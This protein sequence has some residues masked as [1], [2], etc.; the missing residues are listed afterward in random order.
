LSL[1]KYRS[2]FHNDGPLLIAEAE[3]PP[4]PTHLQTYLNAGRRASN[5]VG[6]DMSSSS[7]GRV[8][9]ASSL[10]RPFLSSARWDISSSNAKVESQEDQINTTGSFASTSSLNVRSSV[11]FFAQRRYG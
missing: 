9:E 5:F 3:E 1:A 6:F 8:Q 11:S 7:I 10:F 2:S 4:S